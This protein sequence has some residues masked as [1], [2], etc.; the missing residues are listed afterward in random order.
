MLTF[1]KTVGAIL[2]L[3]LII[4]LAVWAAT[5]N[6]RHG[7]HGFKRYWIAMSFIVVP[8]VLVAMAGWLFHWLG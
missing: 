1:V 5:G 6:W 4:P 7:L 2:G 8:A 3:S